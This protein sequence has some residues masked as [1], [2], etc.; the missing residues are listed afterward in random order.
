MSNVLDMQAEPN[1]WMLRTTSKSSGYTICTNH[2]ARH[3]SSSTARLQCA[4]VRG[5]GQLH[6]LVLLEIWGH[7]LF[8][9]PDPLLLVVFTT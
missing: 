4:Q 9:Q 8:S 1:V 7:C 3:L 6:G 5:Q 2:T